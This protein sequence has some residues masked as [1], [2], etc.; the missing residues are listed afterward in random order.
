[1]SANGA[2]ETLEVERKYAVTSEAVLPSA[3]AFERVG[4]TP[5]SP[6]SCAL[7]AT[8]FDTPDG[9]LGRQRVAVRVR[10]GGKDEGWHMKLKGADGSRELVWPLG[11]EM[12]DGLRRDIVDRIGAE[13]TDRLIAVAT[14][15]TTRTITRLL[16]A[17]GAWRV[18]LAD[19]AVVAVNGLTGGR[20][21]WREWEAELAPDAAE[22][23]LDRVEPL[24]VAAGAKRVRG[25]SKLQ[26]A[27]G[28]PAS[29]VHDDS[30][31]P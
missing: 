26:R 12:P 20:D 30:G 22:A 14:L 27:L 9:D 11:A 18:E 3:A 19:D 29:P 10:A 2:V 1:M 28:R 4:F 7:E 15:H 5:T 6:E 23:L 17:T 8:Y 31:T 25:T 24:L 13:A 21:A 16:D